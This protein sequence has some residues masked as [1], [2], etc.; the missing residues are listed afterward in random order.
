MWRF[1]GWK[2]WEERPLSGPF[3]GEEVMVRREVPEPER[4]QAMPCSAAAVPKTPQMA[5]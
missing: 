2:C 1:E 4:S 3:G 5:S